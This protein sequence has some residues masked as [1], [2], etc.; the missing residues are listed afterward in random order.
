MYECAIVQLYLVSVLGN[1]I[2]FSLIEFIILYIL[3]VAFS[4]MI[5]F[6]KFDYCD[7]DL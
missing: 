3:F 4:Y 7:H 5:K 6:K 1:L 2:K